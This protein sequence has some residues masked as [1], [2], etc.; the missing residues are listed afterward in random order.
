MYDARRARARRAARSA[1]SSSP[2]P[3]QAPRRRRKRR[4]AAPAYLTASNA[5]GRGEDERGHAGRCERDV[6]ERRGR[7]PRDRRDPAGASHLDAPGHDV[8]HRRAT[9][10]SRIASAVAR[11]TS[12]CRERRHTETVMLLLGMNVWS[13]DWGEQGEDWSG[14]GA[15]V[16][17]LVPRGPLLGASLYEL[18]PG[19]FVVFHFHHGSEE[20]LVVLRGTPTLRTMD[21][22]R[23]ARGGR[24]RPLPDRPRRRAR[25][26]QRHRH[27]RPLRHG[28]HA[29]L[30]G[31]RR[32]PG[33][34]P[35][36]P[37]SRS[38]GSSSCH[39]LT[40]SD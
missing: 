30:A 16:K 37:G 23:R 29:R 8:E 28:R 22:E 21:G 1:S 9:G 38:T 32:V 2:L 3:E 10:R 20:L 40:S 34:E 26:P 6:R 12:V 35:G 27:A 18:G 24:G 5:T 19:N 4:Y 11:K 13:D 33:P 36:R 7:D 39:D 15:L 31:G 25:D 14:G 17:R